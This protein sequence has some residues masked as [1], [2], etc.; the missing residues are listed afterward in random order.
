MR[1]WF[2]SF[3]NRHSS[4]KPYPAK[5]D[6]FNIRGENTERRP[7]VSFHLFVY[8]KYATFQSDCHTSRYEIPLL[9][10]RAV[11]R[12]SVVGAAKCADSTAVYSM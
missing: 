4:P 3:S 10:P 6:V 1:C 11:I 5:F 2:G 8:K 9:L 7:G 12:L